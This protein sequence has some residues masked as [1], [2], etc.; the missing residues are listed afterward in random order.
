[1]MDFKKIL[2]TGGSG[3][4]GSHVAENLLKRG[5]ASICIYDIDTSLAE[6]LFSKDNRVEI[7]RGDI[8]DEKTVRE[9]VKE[10]DAIIHMAALL[11]VERT[12]EI[13]LCGTHVFNI[14]SPSFR[15]GPLL[16]KRTIK[17]FI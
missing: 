1:M 9:C 16:V 2:V 13:R 5:A 17:K 10:C 14:I 15:E 3:F 6:K 12:A 4:I 7:V 8:C 11:G